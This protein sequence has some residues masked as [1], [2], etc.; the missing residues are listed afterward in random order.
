MG[1]F[2]NPGGALGGGLAVTG[3]YPG[4]ARSPDELRADV[5]ADLRVPI[6]G[7]YLFSALAGTTWC[8]QFFFYSMDETLHMASIIIGYG[9]HLK[10]QH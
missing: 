6:L 8:F 4:K 5:A 2:K 3:N 10:S 7:N 9:T 1:G